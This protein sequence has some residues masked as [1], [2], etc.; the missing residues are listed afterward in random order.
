MCVLAGRSDS[1]IHTVV[2]Q[3]NRARKGKMRAAVS[4]SRR[5]L[6][7]EYIWMCDVPMI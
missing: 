4:A 2:L 7:Y 5:C 6:M 3:G 1:Q